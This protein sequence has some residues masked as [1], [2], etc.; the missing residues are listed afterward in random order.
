MRGK[1]ITILITVSIFFSASSVH[2]Q[3]ASLSL[4]S[5]IIIQGQLR[6]IVTGVPIP[7]AHIINYKFKRA[8]ISDTLGFFTIPMHKTDTL[9][10]T[11]I[12]YEDTRFSLPGFWPSNHY[13][14]VIYVKEKIY[15]IE[16]VIVHGLGTYE[17]FKQ[18]VLS[19]DLSKDKTLKM[20]NYY[21]KL[22]TE[23]AIKYQKVS[24][25]FSFSLRSP[26]ER[27]LHKLEKIQAEQR[28]QDMINSKFNKAI[29]SKLT[30]LQGVELEKFMRYC[31]L[32]ENFILN[33]SEYDILVRVKELYENYKLLQNKENK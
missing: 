33:A 8:T 23:E 27:S 20:Q 31:Q 30:G 3:T 15:H 4:D 1:I 18:K 19:L 24:T 2:G 22:L 32:P 13:S 6:D 17:Q 14:G 21:D 12:G 25:G 7:Y 26:E 11:A 28:K 10:I 29:I 9:F 5:L 16:G